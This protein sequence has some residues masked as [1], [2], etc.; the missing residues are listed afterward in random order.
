MKK[1]K[2][3]YLIFSICCF[4]YSF[5]AKPEK[6]ITVENFD[7]QLEP[8]LIIYN[9]DY[10]A[11]T[12]DKKIWSLK[13]DLAKKY[14]ALKLISFSG[15]FFKLYGDNDKI[16]TVLTSRYGKAHY[17]SKNMTAIS[18]VKVVFE[19]GTVLTT[20][21]LTWNDDSKLLKT[22]KFVRIIKPSGEK[23]EG[24]GLEMDQKAEIVT[25]KHRVSGSFKKE[26]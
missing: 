14:D 13:A 4:I 19:D 7:P 2:Y 18:N 6:I 11:T 20:D 24:Y 12:K 1:I 23:I 5:C 3:K 9:F 8:D 10:E 15:V 26:S 25:I 21:E 22:D 17:D 16:S